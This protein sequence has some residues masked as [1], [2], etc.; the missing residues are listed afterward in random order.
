[1]SAATASRCSG[2]MKRHVVA[3]DGFASWR[4]IQFLSRAIPQKH[5]VVG[6]QSH[7]DDAGRFDNGSQHGGIVGW[8]IGLAGHPEGE[9][10]EALRQM[11]WP[12]SSRKMRPGVFL[13][14]HSDVA[15][16]QQPKGVWRTC[17]CFIAG[18]RS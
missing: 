9:G 13:E 15:N 6:S 3:A 5:R 12:A 18:A 1:M 14:Q 11:T 2:A 4:K 8:Q 7:D 16:M 17:I 10:R